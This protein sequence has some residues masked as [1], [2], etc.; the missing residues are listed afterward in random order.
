MHERSVVVSHFGSCSSPY[1]PDKQTANEKTENEMECNHVC[2]V[3]TLCCRDSRSVQISAPWSLSLS[4]CQILSSLYL[5]GEWQSVYRLRFPMRRTRRTSGAV[6][7]HRS[8]RSIA[9]VGRLTITMSILWMSCCQMV[10]VFSFENRVLNSKHITIIREHEKNGPQR[11]DIITILA[12]ELLQ[13]NTKEIKKIITKYSV[14]NCVATNTLSQFAWSI[15]W[16]GQWKANA[17][18]VVCVLTL[19][20]AASEDDV[21][22]IKRGMERADWPI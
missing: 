21:K 5:L 7:L 6:R 20:F 4:T 13:I 8:E 15:G 2:F 9:A 12:P 14:Q 17:S 11:I 18:F 16:N 3:H 1:R 22:V 10:F 19:T